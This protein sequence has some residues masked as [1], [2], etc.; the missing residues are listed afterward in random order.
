MQWK[1]VTLTAIVFAA[2]GDAVI[3]GGGS[4]GSGSGGSG[5]GAGGTTTGL[6]CDVAAVL[7]AKCISC[8]N[9]PPTGGAPYALRSYADLTGPA[10]APY[11]GQ[12]VAQRSLARMQAATMPPGGGATT[13]EL[14]ALQGWIT[15][16]MPTGSCAAP[17][18]GPVPTTCASGSRW[19]GGNQ[20]NANMNPGLACRACHRSSAP[21]DK[22]YTF[23]GTVFPGMHEANLCNARPPWGVVVEIIDRNGA[24]A[25]TLPVSAASGNFY[26]D[27]LVTAPAFPMPYTAKVVNGTRSATM[28]TPQTDGDC[29]ACHSEQGSGGAPGRIVLP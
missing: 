18:A 13:A 24:V 27:L 5:G 29:N 17:D 8:H 9:A 6:P 19:T 23:A 4:G 20:E 7:Q 16:S 15:A 26:S 22:Q 1:L 3:V 21:W 25:L 2:C 10:P 12:T 14:A 11:A 28:T